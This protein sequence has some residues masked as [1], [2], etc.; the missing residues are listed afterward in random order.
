MTAPVTGPFSKV[1][2]SGKYYSSSTWYRQRK[3]YDLAL[4]YSLTRG[5][6]NYDA[7]GYAPNV[8]E[9]IIPLGDPNVANQVAWA[10][11]RAWSKMID[12]VQSTSQW[13][14]SLFEARQTMNSVESRIGQLVRFASQMKKRQFKKA[15]NTLFD[16]NLPLSR[17][18]KSRSNPDLTFLREKVRG[19]HFAA[20][21]LS[22]QWL[23][24]HFGWVPL[25]EDLFNSLEFLSSENFGSKDL[26][27]SYS[28]PVSWKVGN[29]GPY[30]R[31]SAFIGFARCK[32][33]GRARITNPNA[34]LAARMGLVNPASFL[35]EITPWSFVLDWVSNASQ[36]LSAWSEFVGYELSGT[37]TTK[38]LRL[39][40]SYYWTNYPWYG[41]GSSCVVQRTQGFATP[42]FA[43]KPRSLQKLSA[44][45]AATMMSLLIL[46]L[47]RK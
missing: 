9:Y 31:Q 21:S 34:A 10:Q 18:V 14:V 24:L 8:Q 16:P 33:G 4:P 36:V 39:G 35:L 28:L 43:W 42:G 44:T 3:P 5:Q 45:R 25:F 38:S 11:S 13:A 26:S 29:N 15:V 19:K 47:P 32:Y 23:E 6:R 17:K 27:G 1:V 7:P 12:K 20:K 37:F 46:Q 41:N 30:S 22:S 2:D 40:Y